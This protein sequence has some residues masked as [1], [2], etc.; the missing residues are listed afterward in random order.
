VQ[1]GAGEAVPAQPELEVRELESVAELRLLEAA[2]TEIWRRDGAPPISSELMRALAHSGNYVAGAFLQGRLVAGCLGFLGRPPGGQVRLHS[3]VLGVLPSSQERGAGY[4]LKQHQRRWALE[5]G[6]RE[7]TWTF[8]PLVRRNAYFNISKLGADVRE[9]HLDFYGSMGDGING[10]DASDRVLAVWKLD[11]ERVLQAAAGNAPEPDLE[12]LRAAGARVS[13]A[14][15][16]DG[17]PLV[18]DAASVVLLCQTPAD[19]VALRQASPELAG[20]WRRTLRQALGGALHDGYATTGM[21][22]TGWYVLR[23]G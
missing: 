7:I 22:R 5:R 16:P 2:F 21:T 11:S 17:S 10:D 13:L 8:D 3:H 20:A 12:R 1:S 15:A 6:I 4:A 19:I 23:R 9:Y 14:E 18:G